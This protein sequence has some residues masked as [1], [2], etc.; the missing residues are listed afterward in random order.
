MICQ[1]NSFA[2]D[3][4]RLCYRPP[5]AILEIV[6][7]DQF[8]CVRL[9]NGAVRCFGNGEYG[10]HGYGHNRSVGSA[11]TPYEIGDVL[12]GVRVEG[13]AAGGEHVCALDM[14]DQVYCWGRGHRG[15]LG[16]GNTETIGVTQTPMDVGAIAGI[17]DVAQI[18]AGAEH[19]CVR[20]R[21]GDVRCWGRNSEGQLGQGHTDDVGADEQHP[22][23]EAGFVPLGAASV[24]L[25]CGGNHCCAQLVDGTL[26]CWGEGTHGALGYGAPGNVGDAPRQ[27]PLA[28]VPVGGAVLQVVT[29]RAHSCALL[30]AD[31]QVRCWGNGIHGILGVNDMT[32]QV[33]GDDE[34]A[35]DGAP[36]QIVGPEV[37]AL[38]AG[39]AHTCMVQQGFGVPSEAR[40][41]GTGNLGRLGYLADSDL[42]APRRDVVA[43]GAGVRSIAAGRFH[44][45]ALTSEGGVRCW[46]AGHNGAL[47]YGST[48]SPGA[49]N[50]VTPQQAGDVP[51][52]EPGDPDH[53]ECP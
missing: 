41:W 43:I 44:T 4:D 7:G 14:A 11:Q 23:S 20:Q 19:T 28:P 32:G 22:A 16:Y 9:D 12:V 35:S 47:G 27:E 52:L 42:F 17:T 24:D 48:C 1:G 5:T 18:A 37:I 26:R 38:S 6:A 34:P 10:V 21:S 29:G 45:C 50:S 15:Q 36:V 2:A 49:P 8:S 3:V 51:I 53:P 46:G 30:A 33:I 40:C 39:V 25:S 31:N 13:L